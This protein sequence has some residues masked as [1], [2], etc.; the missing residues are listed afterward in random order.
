MKSTAWCVTEK[1]GAA[2]SRKSGADCG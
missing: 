2:G 1:G